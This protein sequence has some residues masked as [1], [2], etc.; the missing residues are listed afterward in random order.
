MVWYGMVWYGMVE[1]CEGAPVWMCVTCV[2]C[3]CT[4]TNNLACCGGK[5]SVLELESEQKQLQKHPPAFRYVLLPAQ[6]APG[7]L[8]SLI[9]I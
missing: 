7:P 5:R 3:S 8:C 4:L 1:V 6:Q 2:A 9:S